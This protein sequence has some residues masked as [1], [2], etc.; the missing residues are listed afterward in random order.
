MMGTHVVL[1][2]GEETTEVMLGPSTFITSKGF[3]FH[4]GD[5]LEVTGSRITMN[6]IN[7][8]IAREVVKDGKSLRLRDKGGKPQWSGMGMGGPCPAA[9]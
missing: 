9:N 3:S 4:K 1:K 2:I 6:G 7:Y 8:L 5:A